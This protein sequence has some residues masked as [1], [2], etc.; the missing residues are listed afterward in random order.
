[1]KKIDV[2]WKW[3][4]F[5]FEIQRAIFNLFFLPNLG[6]NH[7]NYTFFVFRTKIRLPF[8]LSKVKFVFHSNIKI[9]FCPYN[10]WM[11]KSRFFA[12]KRFAFKP[13][14]AL[15]FF[16]ANFSQRNAVFRFG[17]FSLK[18]FW[19]HVVARAVFHFEQKLPLQ[20]K[21]FSRS[22]S[23]NAVKGFAVVLENVSISY[24]DWK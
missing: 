3:G 12:K 7:L 21:I 13:F 1:M 6:R 15:C 18:H 11:K 17:M 22:N 14:H 24:S 4:Q 9:P 20:C 2:H 5:Q 16:R 19:L 8:N 10:F 23:R